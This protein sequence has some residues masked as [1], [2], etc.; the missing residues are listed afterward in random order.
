MNS[1]YIN[2]LQAKNLSE[3]LRRPQL[4]EVILVEGA[5]QVGKTTLVEQ[6]LA[7]FKQVTKINLEEDLFL[8]KRIDDSLSFD[9]FAM[10][11]RDRYNFDPNLG[12]P[13]LFIDEAQE[14]E[15]LG[16]YVRFMKEKWAS[17]R[18]VLSGSSMTR[19]FRD[20]QRIPVGRTVS[21]HITPFTFPEFLEAGG[22]KGVLQLIDEFKETLNAAAFSPTIHK[23]LLDL[24]D[25]YL[26]IGGLPSVVMTFFH[27]ENAKQLR[28]AILYSQEN[29]FV[30]KT[31]IAD[32]HLF[33]AGL[34]GIANYIGFP[35]KN[36][37]VHEKQ[38]IAEN[39]I[40][41]ETAWHLIYEI[42]QHGM[43]SSSR[44]YPKRYLY[45]I[46]IAQEVRDMPFPRLSLSSTKNPTLRTQ[47]G[48]LFENILLIQLVAHKMSPF[49][50][51]GWKKDPKEQKEVD[52]VW[53]ND[54]HVI[55]IE[56]KASA[57]VTK[58]SFNSLKNYLN[59]TDSH[60]GILLSAAPFSIYQEDGL[61]FA[62]LP[63]YLA[64]GQAIESLAAKYS[65]EC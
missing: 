3:M 33:R 15:K 35:S 11:L 13:I 28:S 42:E 30:R 25:L 38:H 64:N 19:L 27:G 10:L 6:V 29:D 21:V 41:L 7:S 17:A 57:K 23:D 53:R 44:F 31:S 36:S 16:A 61:T 62:N 12:N 43:N 55:P 2:R 37:H 18:V 45:D 51:S 9:E 5:R 52:F 50:I 63:L 1:N 56:C 22:K 40:S 39:I 58:R 32:R 20:T 59:L 24:L 47:L 49:Q 54:Q 26:D 48:G 65:H 8:C 4:R 60:F 46:G 14:S 34:K